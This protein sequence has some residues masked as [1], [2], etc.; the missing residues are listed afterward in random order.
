MNK[1]TATLFASVCFAGSAFAQGTDDCVAPTPLTAFGTVAFDTTVATTSGFDGGGTCATGSTTINQDLFWVFTAPATGDIQFDTD[2]SSYDTKLS[3]H[4]GTDCS[5]TCV[6][7]DD[8]GGAGLQSLIQVLG[9]TQGTQ[10]VVQVGGFGTASGTGVLNIVQYVDPCSVAVDDSFED[11]DLCTAP[12]TVPLGFLSGVYVSTTD[13]DYYRVTVQ[14]GEILSA[15]ASNTTLG[16]VDVA[17]YDASC[18]VLDDPGFGPAEWSTIGAAGPVDLIVEVSMDDFASSNCTEYDLDLATMPDPCVGL[19]A[20]SFEENDDCASALPLGDGFYPG[21]TVFDNDNDYFAVGIDA[22]VTMTADI[23]FTDDI[24]DVDI[25]LWDPAIECDTNVAGTGGAYLVRGFS[26]SDDE[27]ITY[28]NNTGAAQNL[29]IEID[30]FTGL[31]CNTY[32]LQVAGVNGMSGGP[33]TS[34]CSA[35]ANSTGIAS[36]ITATGSR[37]VADNDITLTATDL[38]P[39]AFGFFITSRQQNFVMN[40]AGSAGN[41]CLGGAIGRY[42]GAGQIMNSGTAGEISLTLDLTMIPQPNGFEAVMAGDQWNFQLW[43]RDSSPAGP[44]SNFTNG[45]SIDFI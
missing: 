20:D 16:A 36:E 2:G 22:G 26:A 14:P 33:G 1:F 6:D 21:L 43:H 15:T 13:L 23:F 25:Y 3:V 4:M 30:M 24:A 37:L 34:Y 19:P 38:P 32:D 17:I 12:V 35:N 18:N 28:T 11:N 29:I 45:V 31:G 42:V 44:T 27:Q 39:L 8:D 10:F 5:A 41:L 7:Y 9:V 40:P